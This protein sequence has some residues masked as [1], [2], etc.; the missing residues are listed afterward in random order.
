MGCHRADNYMWIQ[1][2]WIKKERLS[3]QDFTPG[4]KM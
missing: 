3:A 4:G 1:F 2:V